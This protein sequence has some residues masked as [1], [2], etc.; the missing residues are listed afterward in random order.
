MQGLADLLPYGGQRLLEGAT[1]MEYH[2]TASNI[3]GLTF[4]G[5]N[6]NVTLKA[7]LSRENPI[8]VNWFSD[9]SYILFGRIRSVAVRCSPNNAN[10]PI[11]ALENLEILQV[12]SWDGPFTEAFFPLLHPGAEIPCMSLQAIHCAYLEP[13]GPLVSLVK[14]RLQ[15]GHRLASVH[16]PTLPDQESI[17]ELKELVGKVSVD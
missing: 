5:E 7:R 3:Q 16:F 8:P 12:F 10:F 14:A 1:E 13:L 11:A 2:H 17:A 6:V 15:A 9:P 4:Y